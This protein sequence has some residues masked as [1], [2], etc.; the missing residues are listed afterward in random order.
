LSRGS[1]GPI[2]RMLFWLIGKNS[3]KAC[4]SYPL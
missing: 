4:H 1:E 2:P 3:E